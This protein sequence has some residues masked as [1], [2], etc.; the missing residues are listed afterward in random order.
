MKLDEA[1]KVEGP[2][3]PH[4]PVLDLLTVNA[5]GHFANT[6]ANVR[7]IYLHDPRKKG[8]LRYNGFAHQAEIDGQRVT[9]VLEMRESLWLSDVYGITLKTRDVGEVLRYLAETSEHYHPVQNYLNSLPPWDGKT[10]RLPLLFKS[11]FGAILTGDTA[12][13]R[14]NCDRLLSEFGVRFMVSAV[15]RAM[16]PGCKA[17]AMVILMGAQGAG[18]SRA[19]RVLS[20]GWFSDAPLQIGDRDA[21]LAL[22]GVWLY[23]VAELDSFRGRAAQKIKAFLSTAVDR[24]RGMYSRHY[25]PSPRG[26]VFI[27]TTNEDRFLRDSTGNRRFWP[28]HCGEIKVDL[29]EEDVDQLWAEAVALYQTEKRWHL[30][31][32]EEGAL[33]DHQTVYAERDPWEEGIIGFMHGRIEGSTIARILQEALKVPVE[34]CD[35]RAML[36]CAAILRQNDYTSKQVR[37]P[38]TKQRVQVWRKK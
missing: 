24:Y 7:H 36:R 5:R 2:N 13:E 19:C 10:K 22:H 26:C 32:L 28:V 16:E 23:E 20:K 11:Y 3:A 30:T 17:D 25:T 12:E 18:K 9:D 29:L 14:E 21:V 27:G 33:I 15:A 4:R 34:R 38:K 31:A 8:T 37:V 35:K 1:L 6:A